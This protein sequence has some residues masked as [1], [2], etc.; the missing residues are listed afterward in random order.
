MM[1]LA[2]RH[3]V[4]S[5]LAR[6]GPIRGGAAQ[7]TALCSDAQATHSNQQGFESLVPLATGVGGNP[8]R[9]SQSGLSPNPML[10]YRTA[11]QTGS[12]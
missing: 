11:H 6:F 3:D 7:T 8:A 2:D 9:S 10:D 5:H 12:G 4:I 1:L